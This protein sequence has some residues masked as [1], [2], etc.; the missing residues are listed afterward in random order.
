MHL[1]DFEIPVRSGGDF[2][3]LNVEAD[4]ETSPRAP[5]PVHLSALPPPSPGPLCLEVPSSSQQHRLLGFPAEC[6]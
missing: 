5:L 2:P 4:L 1:V 3:N 6:D